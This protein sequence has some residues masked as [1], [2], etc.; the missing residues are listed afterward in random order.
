MGDYE[1]QPTE[2]QAEQSHEKRSQAVSSFVEKDYDKAIQLY[3]DAIN[4]N[5]QNSL[6]Y[7][8]RG[9]IYLLLK[10]PNACIR[11][12]NRAME[13]NPDSAAAHKFR[14][15]AQQL[16]GKFEEAANDLRKACKFDYDE[17]ADEWLKEVTPNVSTLCS[18]V[19]VNFL[20][21]H[22]LKTTPTIHN[23]LQLNLLHLIS[24]I[25]N[26]TKKLY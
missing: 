22:G 18:I 5:P 2:E 16:L 15:R 12:C 1:L 25:N 4:L 6:L 26:L 9:Q 17:Q 24:T 20:K 11:D 23:F 8:K 14:G 7:A 21:Q 19:I 13:L 3:T 10:K